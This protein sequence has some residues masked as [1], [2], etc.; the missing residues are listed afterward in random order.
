MG[1]T[2][3]QGLPTPSTTGREK[4]L[5]RFFEWENGKFKKGGIHSID[6]LEGPQNW[7]LKIL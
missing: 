7:N 4:Y 2:V 1:D 3:P 6:E 5:I